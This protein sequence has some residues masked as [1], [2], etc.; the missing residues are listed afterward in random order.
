MNGYWEDYFSDG[1]L[2]CRGHLLNGERI[3]YWEEFIAEQIYY[4]RM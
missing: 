1:T 2:W 3:G 4:A